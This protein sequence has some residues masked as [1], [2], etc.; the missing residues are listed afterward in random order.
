MGFLSFS[1]FFNLISSKHEAQNTQSKN[2]K[3]TEEERKA[4]TS[5]GKLKQP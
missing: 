2:W 4:S 3:K 5:H 1:V